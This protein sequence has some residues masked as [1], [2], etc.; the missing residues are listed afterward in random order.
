MALLYASSLAISVSSSEATAAFKRPDEARPRRN[1][2]P[3]TTRLGPGR[4]ADVSGFHLGATAEAP[5]G[6]VPDGA[7]QASLTPEAPP[8]QHVD[9]MAAACIQV[10]CAVHYEKLRRRNCLG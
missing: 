10:L 7:P 3:F 8:A 6:R 4:L 9:V 1:T 5:T 2:S